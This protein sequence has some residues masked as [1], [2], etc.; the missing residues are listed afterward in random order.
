IVPEV[1][2]LWLASEFAL[3]YQ[4]QLATD[5]GFGQIILDTE[6]ADISLSTDVLLADTD[7]FWR[8]RSLNT[9][10]SSDWSEIRS[11]STV[12]EGETPDG[13]VGHWKMDEGS[14]NILVDH[15]GNGNDATIQNTIG[16]TWTQGV[17][18]LAL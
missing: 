7:Y 10:G 8:V 5:P 16:V 6:T 13:P 17:M 11:F 15:S 14:G 12:P 4:L 18:G 9:G 3:G 1:Q 2:F